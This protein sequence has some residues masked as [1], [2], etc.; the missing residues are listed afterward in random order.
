MAVGL[1]AVLRLHSTAVVMQTFG[2]SY[3]PVLLSAHK[4]AI[5]TG[6]RLRTFLTANLLA[7]GLRSG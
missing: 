7:E 2:S 4:P 6:V 5:S 1:P 3:T